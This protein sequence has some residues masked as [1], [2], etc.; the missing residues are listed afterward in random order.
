MVIQVIQVH[1][2]ANQ[3]RFTPRLVLKQ[4]HKEMTYRIIY[5]KSVVCFFL[6]DWH[7]AY[8]LLYRPRQLEVEDDQ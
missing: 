5:N 2:H 7:C 3:T 6:G 1:F 4:S 8:V